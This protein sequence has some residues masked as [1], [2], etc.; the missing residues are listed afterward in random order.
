M[1]PL[2]IFGL[3]ISFA[4]IATATTL[5]QLPLDEMARQSTVI[6]RAKVFPSRAILRNGAV[7]TLYRIETLETLKS[8]SSLSGPREVAVPGGVAGGVRQ[9]VEGAPMLR[10]GA[11]Y[12]L[13]LWTSR[14]GL[15]QIMG[16]SQGLF[17]LQ[18][19]T[20]HRDAADERMLNAEGQPVRDA[21]LVMPF[22]QLKAHIEQAL[23]SGAIAANRKKGMR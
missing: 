4:A 3:L 18:S 13:F 17:S 6:V 15:T 7:Y 2:T 16:L 22:P 1:R 12:V 5:Q 8:D 11:E 21:A 9:P 19:G 20:A 10:N 14:S 23:R